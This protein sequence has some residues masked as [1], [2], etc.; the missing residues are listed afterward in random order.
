MELK[1]VVI[2]GGPSTGKT[3][4]IEHLESKGFPC[5]HELIR[6]MT[7]SEKN[8]A[9][10]TDFSVNPIV[11]VKDPKKFN[12]QLLEGRIKQYTSVENTTGEVVF[13]DRGI[14]DVHAYM[15]C[16][17]QEYDEAF[18]RPCHIYRYDKIL[19]MPP[20]KEIHVVDNERFE[21]FEEAERVYEYLKS[22]YEKVGYPITLVPKGSIEER[23]EFILKQLNLY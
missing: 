2:T 19:L 13:F 9:G 20:W 12:Q 23:T 16:F 3:S 17:G 8:E 22:T 18:E 4:V 6:S 10:S 15:N 7:L 11:S 1:K 21:S 5:V 14:P